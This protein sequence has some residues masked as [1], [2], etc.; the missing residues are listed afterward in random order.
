MPAASLTAIAAAH[1]TRD[2]AMAVAHASGQYTYQQIAEFF[3]V[4]FTTV[5]RAVC[6]AR[7]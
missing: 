5:G 3:G 4:H 6:A 1:P 7:G 2:A